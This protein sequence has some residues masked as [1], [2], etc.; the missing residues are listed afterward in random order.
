MSGTVRTFVALAL[1][2][3]V[4]DALD[5]A[6]E[7]LRAGNPVPVENLHL[8][9]AFLGDLRTPDLAEIDDALSRIRAAPAPVAF[10][11]WGAFGGDAPRSVHARVAPD[12]A[13]RHLQA[14]VEQAARIAGL[15]L[16]RRRFAPHVTVARLR[17]DRADGAEVARFLARAPLPA[18]PGF[19]AEEVVLYRSTLTREG[20]VYDE[21]E[22]YR[23]A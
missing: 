17:G 15:D 10:T 6:S 3:D 20:P 21:L 8:T 18:L 2:E 11:E 22:S 13:L 1:P 19:T 16:P 14:K 7:G 4:A 23:F 12:P 5:A 9:L